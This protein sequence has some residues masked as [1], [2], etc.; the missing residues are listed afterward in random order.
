MIPYIISC[1]GR[2]HVTVI[3]RPDTSSAAI[4]QREIRLVNY[5]FKTEYIA[6]SGK[7]SGFHYPSRVA[8]DDSGI[9]YFI[10]AASRKVGV[11]SI[12]GFLVDSIPN[13][14]SREPSISSPFN[15]AT[16][17]DNRLLILD[18]SNGSVSSFALGPIAFLSTFKIPR[19]MSISSSEPNANFS[20]K[21][22]DSVAVRRFD[23]KG[24]CNLRFGHLYKAAEVI[25]VDF[26]DMDFA[27]NTELI[28]ASGPFGYTLVCQTTDYDIRAYDP[29]GN[30]M[31]RF[32]IHD[33]A[34]DSL[35]ARIRSVRGPVRIAPPG[36]CLSNAGY[37]EI[38]VLS[39]CTDQDDR[40]W[41][42]HRP[43]RL[44]K[45]GPNGQY[46]GSLDVEK[47]L[48]HG[49]SGFRSMAY[50]RRHH[51][52]ALVSIPSGTITMV[53]LDISSSI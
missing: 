27:L 20:V 26:P 35:L 38:E 36:T 25:G 43:N 30:P 32:G 9:V 2:V 39:V 3:D 49:D 41:V 33:D 52:F 45:F 5:T 51:A 13:I 29:A 24:I 31:F 1:S 48:P 12:S 8:C 53:S 44:D 22:G 15:I 50:S 7:M 37:L 6:D 4:Y 40:I 34:H 23:A 10:S 19:P 16:T 11:L 28:L 14:M 46:L 17:V 42:L 21:M 18:L 47:L